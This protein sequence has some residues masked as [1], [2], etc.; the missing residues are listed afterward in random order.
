MFILSPKPEIYLLDINDEES[1]RKWDD[2]VYGS[3]RGTFCHLTGWGRVIHRTF[4]HTPVYLYAQENGKILGV[5]PLFLIKSALFGKMLISNAFAVYGGAV[6]DSVAL[7]TALMERAVEYGQRAGADFV[8]FRSIECKTQSLQLTKSDL[9]VT[10]RQRLPEPPER[11]FALMPRESRRLVRRAREAGLWAE[12]NLDRTDEFYDVY[13]QN[14]RHLGTPVFPKAL[15]RNFLQEFPTSTGIVTVWLGTEI[16][17]AVF[18]F[19]F[20][21]TVMPYYGGSIAKY[22][23]NK[24][25]PNNFMYWSLMEDSIDKGFKWFDFGRSKMNTGSYHFKRHFGFEPQQLDYR[26]ALLK[27]Q[28]LPNIN[29]LNPRFQTLIRLWKRVPL[30]ITK[31]I[32]PH[33]VNRIP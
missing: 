23:S 19:Y 14:M 17:A 8:E 6:A 16:L 29:P 28:E 2:Y 12:F 9:Y 7:E 13:A 21:D 10:F 3:P 32:G 4:E 33:I 22:N 18:V 26:Y 30:P 31:L 5:L 24:I 15:F 1:C 11:S 25:A 27:L 20:R